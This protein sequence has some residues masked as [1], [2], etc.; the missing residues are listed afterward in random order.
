MECIKRLVG[1]DCKVPGYDLTSISK[2]TIS[3]LIILVGEPPMV[4]I[5]GTVN[6]TIDKENVEINILEIKYEAY[7]DLASLIYSI[8]VNQEFDSELDCTSSPSDLEI[9]AI[10]EQSYMSANKNS[11]FTDL[12]Y[13]TE[14]IMMHCFSRCEAKK[15]RDAHGFEA[16]V[17]FPEILDDYMNH[18]MTARGKWQTSTPMISNIPR[19]D[20][21]KR[22]DNMYVMEEDQ[23][24]WPTSNLARNMTLRNGKQL[25]TIKCH[26]GHRKAAI[27]TY[28]NSSSGNEDSINS[29]IRAVNQRL[30]LS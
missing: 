21:E 20:K 13:V 22:I 27:S 8:R 12:A 23:Q 15:E 9:V 16:Q 11:S 25:G 6:L 17:Y 5:N 14:V 3:G 24:S 7:M 29:C 28:S 2:G 18:D 30:Q 10:K 26:E 4:S 19:V 1:G